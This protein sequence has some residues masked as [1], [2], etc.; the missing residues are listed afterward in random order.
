MCG[1]GMPHSYLLNVAGIWMTISEGP[2]CSKHPEQASKELL[3]CHVGL[4]SITE[5]STSPEVSGRDCIDQASSQIQVPSHATGA[6]PDAKPMDRGAI[7]PI[8]LA[9]MAGMAPESKLLWTP[10]GELC[11]SRVR[12]QADPRLD[13]S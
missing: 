1:Y 11:M 8:I 12:F 4:D 7:M 10:V 13:T 3:L 6:D 5:G 2:H 9:G